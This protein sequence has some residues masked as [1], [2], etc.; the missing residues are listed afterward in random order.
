M[1]RAPNQEV[2]AT[3]TRQLE[4]PGRQPSLNRLTP[5]AIPLDQFL[6]LNSEEVDN[7]YH[8]CHRTRKSIIEAAILRVDSTGAA[9]AR[10]PRH[11]LSQ[12]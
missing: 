9:P 3:I 1:D 4:R 10:N 8:K 2:I 5:V 12:L 7:V 11:S 6:G